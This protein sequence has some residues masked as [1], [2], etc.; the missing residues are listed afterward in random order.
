MN[1]LIELSKMAHFIIF[2][3]ANFHQGRYKNM[4]SSHV[5]PAQVEETAIYDAIKSDRSASK[6]SQ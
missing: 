3:S 4:L 2:E 5:Q 1:S 6:L